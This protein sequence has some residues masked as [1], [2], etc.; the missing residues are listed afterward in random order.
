M[1]IEIH[2]SH[3]D[4]EFLTKFT[5][6]TVAQAIDDL[7]SS[8]YPDSVTIKFYDTSNFMSSQ[9]YHEN[10][11]YKN[12]DAFWCEASSL[13]VIHMHDD[14]VY[15]EIHEMLRHELYHWYQWSNWLP[16]NEADAKA[17]ED[18][19]PPEDYM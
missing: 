12:C 6:A 19:L 15:L 7:G 16:Y 9:D 1:R 11:T 10:H 13:I 5:L 18:A 17:F 4:K 8:V 14:R 2:C 3:H